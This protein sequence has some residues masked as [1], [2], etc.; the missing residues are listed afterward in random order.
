MRFLCIFVLSVFATFASAPTSSAQ[1]YSSLLSG[2]NEGSLTPSDKRFLQTVYRG[3][4]LR[5][6]VALIMLPS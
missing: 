6:R 4:V 1:D 3:T 2:F 5:Q